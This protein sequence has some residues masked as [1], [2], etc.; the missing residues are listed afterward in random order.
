MPYK[1]VQCKYAHNLLMWN[2][3]G[4]G[5]TTTTQDGTPDAMKVARPVWGEGKGRG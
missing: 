1:S 2:I 4:K 3:L 5:Y